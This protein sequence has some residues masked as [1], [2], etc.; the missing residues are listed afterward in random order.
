MNRHVP[1]TRRAAEELRRAAREAANRLEFPRYLRARR[2]K[3][4]A[5]FAVVVVGLMLVVLSTALLSRVEPDDVSP[6]NPSTTV[7]TTTTTT[8]AT[9]IPALPVFD[10]PTYH[11]GRNTVVR[12]GFVDGT[13]AELSYPD[14]YDFLSNGIEVQG[15]FEANGYD[16]TFTVRY[17]SITEN[18]ARLRNVTGGAQLLY[19][20]PDPRGRTAELWRFGDD[21]TADY[22]FI[23]FGDWTLQTWDYRANR[24]EA[25]DQ[26]LGDWVESLVG[27]VAD[28]GYPMLTGAGSLEI[29]PVLGDKG[30]PD[31]PD[32]RLGGADGD[33]LLYPDHCQNVTGEDDTADGRLEWCD[34]ASNTRVVASGDPGT[35]L[36]LRANL[37]ITGV[38][39][40]SYEATLSQAPYVAGGDEFCG[41]DNMPAG[42]RDQA[43]RI[44]PLWL[45]PVGGF[46]GNAVKTIGILE[47]NEPVTLTV[48]VG[49]HNQVSQLFDD[50]AWNSGGNYTVDPDYGAVT[51]LPCDSQL[52]Q[53]VGGFVFESQ[54]R[55]APFDVAG[56]AEGIVTV[57]LVGEPCGFTWARHTD[58]DKDFTIT[59]PSDWH[60]APDTLTPALGFPMVVAV[61]T[62]NAPV[63]GDRCAQFATAAFDAIGPTDVLLTI[64]ELGAGYAQAPR[65]ADFKNGAEFVQGD[66][67]ECITDP[68]RLHGGEFR[69]LD[70]GRGFGAILAMGEDVS[71][72]D[73][74]AAW[75][76]LTSFIPVAIEPAPDYCGLPQDLTADL[77]T[78]VP[79]APGFPDEWT[80]DEQT[81][82]IFTDP[83]ISALSIGAEVACARVWTATS[84]SGESFQL[85]GLVGGGTR[86][87]AYVQMTTLPTDFTPNALTF[88][89]DG[90][91]YVEL[92]MHE[93]GTYTGRFNRDQYIGVAIDGWSIDF[94]VD[95]WNQAMSRR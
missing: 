38:S 3:S 53:F 6:I 84:D 55:C 18:V 74:D 61:S 71:Q 16:R 8:L 93:D 76:M 94:F 10:P 2:R 87:A 40:R 75:A 27:Y 1:S 34:S 13:T 5:T 7:P 20:Y 92:Q 32:L 33:I 28:T 79:G 82:T 63:G 36:D 81:L 15:A 86:A 60:V 56:A 37:A 22:L 70:N 66:F 26:T 47:G 21:D 43:T 12:L 24:S 50:S 72:E 44:G 67:Q 88:G 95:V 65:P 54:A 46:N 23:E 48:P 91:G 58:P 39:N 83:S 9:E 30:G 62:F 89:L 25:R 17:G 45:W 78:H 68:E 11:W 19:T 14:G 35:L 59:Y 77:L 80:Q 49:W 57:P 85:V 64:H 69:Y 42:W 52:A 4:T 31:G 90:I 51:F 29:T 73:E 41:E